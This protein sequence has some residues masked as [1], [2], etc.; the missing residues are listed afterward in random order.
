LVEKYVD[1]ISIVDII[2]KIV[3]EK[4]HKQ[5]LYDSI[6]DVGRNIAK[7]HALGIQLGDSKPE[8]FIRN[9]E[10]KVFILDLEQAKK[11]RDFAWDIAVFLYFSAHYS[12]PYGDKMKQLTEAFIHGY[13]EQGNSENLRQA[14]GINYLKVFSFWAFPRSNYI[15]SDTLKKAA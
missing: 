12:T 9:D 7:V 2:K 10:G 5:S 11:G 13:R 4:K 3:S 14:A 1:G 6:S 8:N 15:V